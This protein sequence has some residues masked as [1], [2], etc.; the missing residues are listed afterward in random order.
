M[1]NR[2]QQPSRHQVDPRTK[3]LASRLE[4]GYQRIEDAQRRGEDITAWEQFWIDLLREY[5][6]QSL[7]EVRQ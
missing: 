2:V 6:A 7:E 4:D 1:S 3:S 5:E